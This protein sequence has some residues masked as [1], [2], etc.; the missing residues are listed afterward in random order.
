MK[1][2]KKLLTYCGLYCGTC[3]GHKGDVPDLARDL[4]KLLRKYKFDKIA[5]AIPFKEFKEYEKGYQLLSGLVRLRCK[6]CRGGMRSKFCEIAKCC[7]KKEH[8]GCWK[9]SEFEKCKKLK[10]LEIVHKD[11]HIKNLKQIK[12]FGVKGYLSKG[13]LDW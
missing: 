8:E 2:D 13:K 6:G 7:L 12:K 5:K 1:K 3:F 4:R 10:F 11:A 9:C